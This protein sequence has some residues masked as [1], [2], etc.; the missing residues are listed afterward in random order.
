MDPGAVAKR[1]TLCASCG[2]EAKRCVRRNASCRNPRVEVDQKAYEKATRAW[3]LAK[4]PSKT[5]ERAFVFN[6]YDYY[7]HLYEDDE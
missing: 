4:R 1:F 6:Y 2:P 3:M 5:E 7:T